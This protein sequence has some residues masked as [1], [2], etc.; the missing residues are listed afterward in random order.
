[1]S[2]PPTR[3]VPLFDPKG[4]DGRTVS[5]SPWELLVNLRPTMNGYESLPAPRPLGLQFAGRAKCLA[6]IQSFGESVIALLSV[7]VPA[8][9][10]LGYR[11]ACRTYS[12][13][14]DQRS[15]SY[16]N[17]LE[18]ALI[19]LYDWVDIGEAQVWSAAGMT[20]RSF[21]TNGAALFCL[22]HRSDAY[23]QDKLDFP[24]LSASAN[25]YHLW[26]MQFVPGLNAVNWP[27]VTGRFTSGLVCAHL[28][29]LFFAGFKDQQQVTLDYELTD[30]QRFLLIEKQLTPTSFQIGPHY[31]AWSD[32]DAPLSVGLPNFLM[33]QTPYPIRALASLKDR[34]VVVTSNDVW[35]LVGQSPAE[36]MLRK[37]SDCYGAQDARTIC[38]TPHGVVFA[39]PDGVFLTD[40]DQSTV[41]LDEQID[42]LFR[43]GVSFT[44]APVGVGA[45]WQ[46]KRTWGTPVYWATRDEL[47]LPV[48]TDVGAT[49]RSG[50]GVLALVYRFATQTWTC[51]TAN[52][53]TGDWTEGF[54]QFG[55]VGAA[56][57][58]CGTRYPTSSFMGQVQI[59]RWEEPYHGIK[60]PRGYYAQ[61][62]PF[63]RESQS[64]IFANGVNVVFGRGFEPS[65]GAEPGRVWLYGEQQSFD[66]NPSRTSQVL[67]RQHPDAGSQHKWGGSLWKASPSRAGMIWTRNADYVNRC[68]GEIQSKFVRF[69][70]SGQS[71]NAVM[72]RGFELLFRSTRGKEVG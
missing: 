30:E 4:I 32:A 68:D 44:G 52:F 41:R 50:S 24:F 31:L 67:T 22:F 14:G 7:D 48:M 17:T 47:W 6:S 8:L 57:F 29:H 59:C 2:S 56:L 43:P 26:P 63:A 20:N 51:A 65:T 55:V 69:A 12:A 19:G 49:Y 53:N 10:E 45:P 1:M 13:D 18:T 42:H 28:S 23:A 58:S 34:L 60:Y 21:F 46:L 54:G 37:V 3:A 62:K 15:Y 16:R 61:S 5:D 64:W 27:Y 66:V 25:E 40:G 39:G 71:W 36:F 72:I 9:P 38:T 35:A 70:L 11:V 33:V